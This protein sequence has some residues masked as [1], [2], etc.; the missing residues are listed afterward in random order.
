MT[1]NRQKSEMAFITGQ[2]DASDCRRP[3]RNDNGSCPPELDRGGGAL[4]GWHAGPRATGQLRIQYLG[5]AG[6][7]CALPVVG[8]LL[9]IL[10]RAEEVSKP[11]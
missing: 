8:T 11:D 9:A 2:V 5:I 7:I 1:H 4:P 6:Y 3:A 10:S